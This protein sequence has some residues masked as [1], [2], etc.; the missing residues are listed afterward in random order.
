MQT[1]KIR[2]AASYNSVTEKFDYFTERLSLPLAL[3]LISLAKITSHQHILDIGTGT[4]VVALQVAQLIDDVT[5]TGIDLSEEMLTNAKQKA[6]KL[7][8][9]QKTNFVQMDAENLVFENEKFE[10]V[11]SLFAL[12]HFPNP[13]IALTE[14]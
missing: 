1:F 5:V 4:G 3:R 8:L 12:L 2:D 6:V 13:L 11:V 7:K 14:I 10:T 9:E